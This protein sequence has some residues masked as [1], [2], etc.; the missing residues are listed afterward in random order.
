MAI[1]P[2]EL[3]HVKFFTLCSTVAQ[4]TELLQSCHI[5]SYLYAALLLNLHIKQQTCPKK[6]AWCQVYQNHLQ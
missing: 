4:P 1:F 6:F 5:W 3:P 2:T